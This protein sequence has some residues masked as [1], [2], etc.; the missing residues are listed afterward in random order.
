M[1]DVLFKYAEDISPAYVV[2][3]DGFSA[4]YESLRTAFA[5]QYPTIIAQSFKTN[6]SKCIVKHGL[7][8]D[9][10][11]E[12]VSPEEYDYALDLGYTPKKIVLNGVCKNLTVL[13][14]A[15]VGGSVINLDSLSDAKRLMFVLQMNRHKI[16]RG[17][18][19]R[20]NFDVGTGIPSRFGVEPFGEEFNDMVELL[21]DSGIPVV[22]LHSHFHKARNAKHWR[23]RCETMAEIAKKIGGIKYL[24]LG[25]SMYSKLNDDMKAHF[26]EPVPDYD[27][28]ARIA[29]EVMFK[30]FGYDGIQL[31]IE[32]GTPL[33]AH[34]GYVVT[35]VLDI[36]RI[37]DRKYAI[38][39]ISSH[40]V[41]SMS[42]YRQIPLTVKPTATE[43][44]YG[45]YD[46]VGCTCVEEDF[47][48]Q[49]YE[50]E[51]GIGDTVILENVGAYC[52]S[53]AS[54]FIRPKLKT[55]KLENG[56]MYTV[57]VGKQ[58]EEII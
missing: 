52:M 11:A 45:T 29:G 12:V 27:E 19:I 55:Y 58:F 39:D 10:M 8:H 37:G 33:L 54:D 5:K 9:G 26:N 23:T 35:R 28:Y 57:H 13:E 22:G 56:E 48:S 32:P 30:N 15:F 38:L 14:K 7:T 43:R 24:D 3:M 40:D 53:M 42:Q 21:K 25:G 44:E 51:L 31:I 17:V 46:M 4:D 6:Y 49:A 41:Y 34:N 2:D 18:G 1:N 20:L 36:K 47:V 50:G 16:D